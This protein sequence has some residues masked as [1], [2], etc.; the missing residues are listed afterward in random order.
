M[1]HSLAV[2]LAWLS[3]LKRRAAVWSWHCKMCHT[4]CTKSAPAAH[5]TFPFP[6]Q[7]RCYTGMHQCLECSCGHGSGCSHPI[8]PW[9]SS[10]VR[11]RRHCRAASLHD[12]PTP[13]A[14]FLRLTARVD[15]VSKPAPSPSTLVL[16][17]ML[18]AAWIGARC[19][20][21]DDP[22]PQHQQ[23]QQQ[24]QR[25]QLPRKYKTC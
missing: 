15:A 10:L 14:T 9:R 3:R 13:A 7:L 21:S 18:C 24:R 17:L 8:W 4:C 25:Q 22:N 1:A 16:P 11:R 5:P 20:R 19:P 2:L 6:M 12:T 23:P